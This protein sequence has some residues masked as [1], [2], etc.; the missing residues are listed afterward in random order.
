LKFNYPDH[1]RYL[2]GVP[3]G[4]SKTVSH[5]KRVAHRYSTKWQLKFNYP[6]HG[7]SL[8]GDSPGK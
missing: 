8:S 3:P 6:D 5:P 7:E 4:N 1:G 2:S